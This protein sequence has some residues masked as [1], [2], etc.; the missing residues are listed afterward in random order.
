MVLSFCYILYNSVSLTF[1]DLR[2]F[3]EEFP[4]S[5]GMPASSTTVTLVG[6]VRNS[7]EHETGCKRHTISPVLSLCLC[8]VMRTW[9]FIDEPLVFVQTKW[10][11]G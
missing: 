10:M 4:L 5:E 1:F 8:I 3:P 6:E 9:L 2:C 7:E 11:T